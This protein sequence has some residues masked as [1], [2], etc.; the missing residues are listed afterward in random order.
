MACLL[1]YMAA[2]TAAD[3][4]K[5]VVIMELERLLRFDDCD[6]IADLRGSK[7]AMM[8]SGTRVYLAS[9]VA[10]SSK[11]VE[12]MYKAIFEHDVVVRYTDLATHYDTHK[13]PTKECEQ[14][15]KRCKPEE[16]HMWKFKEVA[17]ARPPSGSA[18][19]A[20]ATPS[21]CSPSTGTITPATEPD[22]PCSGK[23]RGQSSPAT[24]RSC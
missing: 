4:T 2:D 11:I 12:A 17:K 13:V 9:T 24:L 1:P 20:W 14:Q 7:S 15:F 10:P 6:V 16:V 23:R 22:V 8:Q 19:H 5:L 18:R 3:E 21:V